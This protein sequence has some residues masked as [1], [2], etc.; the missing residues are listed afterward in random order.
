MEQI[1]QKHS[2]ELKEL[3]T[4]FESHRQELL[5]TS[6]QLREKINDQELTIRVMEEDHSE[7]VKQMEHRLAET[8]S[9]RKEFTSQLSAQ[10]KEKQAL[11]KEQ[12]EKYL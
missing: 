10:E 9:Y 3:Q 8:E 7:K 12:E 1:A 5:E 4:D 6:T 2:L 11:L